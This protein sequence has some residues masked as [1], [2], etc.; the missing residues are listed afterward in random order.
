MIGPRP[1]SAVLFDYGGTLVTF[2][3][4]D[5]ALEAAYERIVDY[6]RSEGWT[7]PGAG[8]LLRDVH[9]RVEEAFVAHQ[10]SGALEEINLV[11]VASQAY[12]D[13]GLALDDATLDETLRIEQEAW[14]E[15]VRVDPEA[16]P[17]I[18]GLRARGLRVGLCSNA[19]YRIPSM[20]AQLRH[21]AL[22]DRLDSVTFSGQIGWR[23][24]SPRIMEAAA[25]AVGSPPGEIVLVGDSVSDDVMGARAVG[26]RAVL[27]RR[28]GGAPPPEV[29]PPIVSIGSLSAIALLLFGTPVL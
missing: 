16:V 4:P 2:R 13:L 3:R 6:L 11:A 28:P 9:D 20:H 23:K 17:T 14:W 22:A 5:A 15:G 10:R 21:F 7:P 24:P 18:D 29:D 27:L 8:A 25:A 26:M 12:A 19:P 1:V